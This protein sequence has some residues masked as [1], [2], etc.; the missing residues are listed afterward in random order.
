MIA[1]PKALEVFPEQAMDL[2]KIRLDISGAMERKIKIRSMP[3]RI[4]GR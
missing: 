4:P 1:V 2:G 3:K